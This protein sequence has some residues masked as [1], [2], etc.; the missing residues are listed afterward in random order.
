MQ[1]LPSFLLA[2]LCICCWSCQ[3]P[4]TEKSQDS[5]SAKSS[6]QGLQ[7]QS[8]GSSNFPEPVN[9][10]M[11]RR[12][13]VSIT[14]EQTYESSLRDVKPERLDGFQGPLM[15]KLL[16]SS[17]GTPSQVVYVQ[18][19][20][21]SAES[22]FDGTGFEWK[23]HELTDLDV[24]WD[25]E[26]AGY[27]YGADEPIFEFTSAQFDEISS[28]VGNYLIVGSTYFLNPQEGL[29]NVYC[30]RTPEDELPF[31]PH[32]F[33][34][35]SDSLIALADPLKNRLVLL[36][37]K[38]AIRMVH[39]LAFSPSQLQFKRER[40]RLE[41]FDPQEERYYEV[42]VQNYLGPA[43]EI[44]ENAHYE[45]AQV[46]SGE[47]TLDLTTRQS[48]WL[49]FKGKDELPADRVSFQVDPKRGKILAVH[50]LGRDKE[51]QKFVLLRM[52]HPD[53]GLYNLIIRY[54]SDNQPI[55]T[56]EFSYSPQVIYLENE[57]R[58]YNSQVYRLES[59]D[60]EYFVSTYLFP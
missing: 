8:I 4:E 52:E 34:V 56:L 31:G 6:N 41:V 29:P 54:D 30:I 16:P 25:I 47:E 39:K 55:S 50:S 59:K 40:K 28:F 53:N 3:T 27:T 43:Q 58:I 42:N 12:F 33:D 21:L 60:Q 20:Q 17:T 7:S 1:A 48:G 49:A 44:T 19:P 37:E 5:S 23:S 36:N 15:Q 51:N 45:W 2:F 32:S 24:D 57:F 9:G 38:G 10:R 13:Q 22:I 11:V 46:F 14:W 35:L 18:I 26:R